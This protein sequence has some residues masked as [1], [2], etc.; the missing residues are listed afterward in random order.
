[1]KPKIQTFLLF[2][3]AISC[4]SGF[5]PALAQAPASQADA[6][7][8]SDTLKTV[9]YPRALYPN[10]LMPDWDRGFVLHYEFEEN[11]TPDTPM[12]EVYDAEGVRVREGRIWPKG[13]AAVRIRRTAA[14]HE[15]AILAAGWAIMQDKSIQHYLVKTD[16]DGATIQTLLTGSF[17]SEQICEA[18]EGTVWSLGKSVEPDGT[19]Q[20]DVGVL[21]HFS[22]EKG[23]LHSFLPVGTVEALVRSNK[24]WFSPFLSFVRCGKNKVSV[25]LNFTNEYA[26]VDTSTFEVTRWK[27]DASVSLQRDVNGLA[28]TDDGRVFMSFDPNVKPGLPPL[29]GLYQVKAVAGRPVAQLMPVSGTVN[30]LEP[31][32]VPT[33]E[34][35]VMLFGADGNHLVVWRTGYGSSTLC[36]VNVV[37]SDTD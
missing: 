21:Q 11:D 5:S 26:E 20:H 8:I 24:P 12:V 13:A 9:A 32:T 30:A 36:W 15:G 10:G 14:T 25:Y 37:Q 2:A 7:R 34:S 6:G 23:L 1:M 16:L 27:L 31:G 17:A 19:P 28:I 18:P 29:R 4:L 35:F 3:C 22:L 33:P